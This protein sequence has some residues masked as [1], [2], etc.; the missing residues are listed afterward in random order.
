MSKATQ[1]E[2]AEKE[3]PFSSCGAV[4]KSRRTP[5]DQAQLHLHRYCRLLL[6]RYLLDNREKE[7][8]YMEMVESLEVH[9]VS[10]RGVAPK[11]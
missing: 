4:A 8:I 11:I 3:I 1:D 5:I 2:L 9:H 7:H 10:L 6:A